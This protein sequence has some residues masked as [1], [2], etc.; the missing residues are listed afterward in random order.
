EMVEKDN[1]V[2]LC[3]DEYAKGINAECVT[4]GQQQDSIQQA[5]QLFSALRHLD[6]I[7]AEKAYATMPSLE[8]VGLAVYN[9]LLRAAAFRVVNL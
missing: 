1:A 4:Y 8:G 5:Q 3:F 2:A 7:G 9:R 6:E